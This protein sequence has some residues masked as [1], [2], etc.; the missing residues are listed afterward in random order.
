MSMTVV[1]YDQS[2][3]P[4]GGRLF[5]YLAELDFDSS[6]PTGG[7]P[8]PTSIPA[9]EQHFEDMKGVYFDNTQGYSLDYDRDNQKVKAFSAAGTEV[10]NATD[11]SALTGINM[12]A[13][14][15]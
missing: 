10:P 6:Y 7:Y 4:I 1:P 8:W 2:S 15:F 3:I 9:P 13:E 12:R 14:G 5:F 11:L